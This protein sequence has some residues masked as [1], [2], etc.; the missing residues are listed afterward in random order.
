MYIPFVDTPDGAFRILA[1]HTHSHS[2]VRLRRPSNY[3]QGGKIPESSIFPVRKEGA[4]AGKGFCSRR[5]GKKDKDKTG[6][7][8]DGRLMDGRR[9]ARRVEDSL[10]EALLLSLD[11]KAGTV[12][13]VFAKEELT[14]IHSVLMLQ[15]EFEEELLRI[16]K[17]EP[18]E[19]RLI[20]FYCLEARQREE[21]PLEVE[22]VQ[23]PS[24]P[25]PELSHQLHEEPDSANK[26]V[27]A[28]VRDAWRQ[29]DSNRTATARRVLSTYVGFS[30]VFESRA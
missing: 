2:T 3:T 30:R 29:R 27:G 22:D 20:K 1:L 11:A 4:L 8:A 26:S 10:L 7:S 25:P 28:G 6:K 16:A 24:E 21:Q 18:D 12:A 15:S 23:W 14:S 13:T 17:L 19:L 5:M 9:L